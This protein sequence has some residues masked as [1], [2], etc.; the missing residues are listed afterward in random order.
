MPRNP[1]PSI[2]RQLY[3]E[4][5]RFDFY[6][7]VRLLEQLSPNRQPPGENHDPED[8][9][10]AFNATIHS[11]FPAS[12]LDEVKPADPK[13]PAPRM[14][15]N[16][17]GLAGAHGALPP[18]YTELIAERVWKGDRAMRDFLDIFNHRLISLLYRVRQKHRI[19]L[20]GK[21]PWQSRFARFL[22]SFIGLGTPGLQYRMH[23]EDHALLFYAGL[24]IHQPRSIVALEALLKDY[25]Q[26]PARG[27]S[28]SGQWLYLDTEEQTRLGLHQGRHHILGQ[29]A[30][31]GS[32]V[33]DQENRFE[34]ELGPLSLSEFLNFLPIGWAFVPLTEL[35][36]FFVGQDLDYGFRLRLKAGE[37]PD[38]HLSGEQH[39]ARL[40]WTSWL[41]TRPFHAEAQISLNATTTALGGGAQISLLSYLPQTELEVVMN[42]VKTHHFPAHTRVMG[43]GEQGN[44]LF[45]I[46]TGE[47]RVTYQTLEGEHKTLA[48]LGAGEFF[49]EFAFFTGQHRSA[50]VITTRDSKI[51]ELEKNDLERI[52]EQHPR[53]AQ[54]IHSVYQR[55]INLNQ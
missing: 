26:V 39:G 14:A 35:I 51:L 46:S 25:F 10:V 19:G 11:R 43:Q 2:E 28:F 53:I 38:C 24:L 12:A 54:V 6:Q 18:P 50:T 29:S 32:R 47:V 8:D 27:I 1:P 31:L 49:G 5:F 55:R 22:F 3:E 9:C 44:S 15:V 34:V 20:E 36:R 37:V 33:W 23:I 21:A 40:G 17:L 52:L 7:A 30:T 41:K 16:F 45:I 42:K 4:A 48:T 13:H